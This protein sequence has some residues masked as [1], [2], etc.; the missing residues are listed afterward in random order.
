MLQLLLHALF[1]HTVDPRSNLAYFCT[2]EVMTHVLNSFMSVS[3]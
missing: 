3:S 1:L 2:D